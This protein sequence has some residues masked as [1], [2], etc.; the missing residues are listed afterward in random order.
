M[1]SD[2]YK[3]GVSIIREK[4]KQKKEEYMRILQKKAKGKSVSLLHMQVGL[5][6]AP[7]RNG[8]VLSPE[9]FDELPE[10]EKQELIN[11]LNLM[12]EEIEKAAKDL[13]EWED[14][15]RRESSLLRE[16]FIK[17]AVKNPI[18]SLRQKY[19]GHRE[20]IEFL[21]NIQNHIVGN[22]DEFLPEE[23]AAPAEESDAL[24]ALLSRMNKQE[25]DKFAKFKVN[26]VVKNE[27]DSGA[28]IVHLDHPTQGKLVGRVER[29]QQYGALLTD[30]T[31]IKAGALHRAN[32]GF[33]LIDARKLLVQPYAW[34]SL[35]R[36]L[37]SKTIKIESPGEET[38]FT[39]ISLDPEPI[40]LDVKVILTG[41]EE[42]YDLL[43]E[44]DPDFSD[45]FKVEAD[46]GT[47]MDRNEENEIEY[48]RLIGSLSNKKKLRTLNKQAVARVIEYSS[49]LAE[50][51]KKLTAHIASIGD[52]LRE[53]DYWARESNSKQI[54]KK[55]VDQA[56][57]AQIYRSD[58]IK[59]AMLEQIDDGTIMIDVEGE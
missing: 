14:R 38:S 21:K 4:Y 2:E 42:L 39:T 29:I 55:H 22:I 49:R 10:N 53:A 8:E 20:A 23:N 32:G 11:D 59:Q 12:Q 56:I 19:K 34:D 52:L 9:A 25:E 13:P 47:L 27:P 57:A 30:F 24:S 3:A 5:V 28:P 26:V 37:A 7:V 16:K 18:D 15:Q 46:F 43:S 33:L 6:V 51:S 44:R 50:D 31:L 58:R 54:G 17:L 40:P 35:K 48:A 45:Y 41:D 1:D 36:A